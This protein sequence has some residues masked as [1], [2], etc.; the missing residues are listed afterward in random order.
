MQGK[1]KNCSN[2]FKNSM[3]NLTMIDTD[4]FLAI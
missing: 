1:W 3:K 4:K 2:V